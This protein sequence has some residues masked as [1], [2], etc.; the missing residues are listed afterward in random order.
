VQ[1]K[2]IISEMTSNTFEDCDHMF[3][4]EFLEL[5]RYANMRFNAM[6]YTPDRGSE[7]TAELA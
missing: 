2:C 3:I 4:P 6:Y 5:A 1:D 7:L